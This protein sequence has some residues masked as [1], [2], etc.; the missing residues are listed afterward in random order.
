MKIIVYFLPFLFLMSCGKNLVGKKD[1][2]KASLIPQGLRGEGGAQFPI[3]LKCTEV[4][5]S[6]FVMMDS[7]DL[8]FYLNVDFNDFDNL[9]DSI[10]EEII[11]YGCLYVNYP[12]YEEY[13]SRPLVKDA[14]SDSI[15]QKY[16]IRGLIR[17]Y[18]TKEGVLKKNILGFQLG[19]Y[20]LFILSKQ[21]TIFYEH[22]TPCFLI[23]FLHV[24][25]LIAW[26]F[27]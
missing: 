24:R 1:I 11:T 2:Y 12:M 9:A 25:M 3:W 10:V 20:S 27:L 21:Y 8:L 18:V 22:E 14:K 7:D 4:Q 5:D 13:K 26:R 15:Y 16:G 19:I 17:E 23:S 6:V